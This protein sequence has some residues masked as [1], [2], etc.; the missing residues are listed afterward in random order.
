MS[1]ITLN[2]PL[3]DFVT[4]TSFREG[5]CKIMA[6][7]L[8]GEN[9][10]DKYPTV[11]RGYKGI[12]WIF[13]NGT[14]FIG[15]GKQ[16]GDDH[17]IMKISGYLAHLMMDNIVKV[18]K[19]HPELKT[20]CSRLDYQITVKEPLSWVQANYRNRM[21]RAGNVVGYPT[22]SKED[23]IELE[24]V[25][26]G[27]RAKV[28]RFYRIYTKLLDD[29]SK[30][31]RVEVELKKRRSRKLFN[32]LVERGTDDIR[33]IFDYEIELIIRQDKKLYK[34]VHPHL[35][36]SVPIRVQANDPNIA[37]W[38]I[39]TVFPAMNRFLASDSSDKTKVIPA[40]YDILEKRGL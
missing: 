28:D 1:T 35:A 5:F 29:K 32:E 25:Y 13:F 40:L 16:K 10:E 12:L 23:G 38:L 17:F 4:L 21:E 39:K 24:T 20:R 19:I 8:I 2:Y 9:S 18:C 3:I 6:D 34:L 37:G 30:V 31:L 22:P 27:V 15:E 26:I 33:M 14:V 11:Q 7:F 36:M